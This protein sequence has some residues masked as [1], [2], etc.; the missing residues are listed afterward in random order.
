MCQW[1]QSH[2]QNK[3]PPPWRQLCR[4]LSLQG[5]V[6]GAIWE[7]FQQGGSTPNWQVAAGRLR[8]RG[9]SGREEDAELS[10][11]W[12]MRAVGRNRPRGLSGQAQWVAWRVCRRPLGGL[13]P[14]PNLCFLLGEEADEKVQCFPGILGPP[15]REAVS[16][17][18]RALPRFPL[19]QSFFLLLST[20][21]QAWQPCR[22]AT[23]MIPA[24]TQPGSGWGSPGRLDLAYTRARGTY[25]PML[26]PQVLHQRR[27]PMA[28]SLPCPKC[29]P[30]RTQ[31]RLGLLPASRGFR[32]P[33]SFAGRTINL[34]A[35]LRYLTWTGGHQRSARA[36]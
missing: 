2:E 32:Q 26:H 31:G 34:L 20:Q 23:G 19:V 6:R 5:Q 10:E 9:G 25:P 12:E 29:M 14:A 22:D 1:Q 11:A 35:H 28:R 36:E 24:P 27:G 8:G 33:L 15:R 4:A 13:W 17:K 7:D 18:S 21:K 3:V 16:R 30:D